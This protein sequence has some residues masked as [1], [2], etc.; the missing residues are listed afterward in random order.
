MEDTVF[1]F[2]LF[3][4]CSLGEKS[5]LDKNRDQTPN[6]AYLVTD[7]TLRDLWLR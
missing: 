3:F 5:D 1:F 7:Q 2:W 6:T 4:C